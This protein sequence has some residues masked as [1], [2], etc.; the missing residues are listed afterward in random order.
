MRI[1]PA[2][3]LPFVRAATA[4]AAWLAF[5]ASAGSLWAHG[6]ADDGLIWDARAI[7]PYT[8]SLWA[9]AHVPHTEIYARVRV[10]DAPAPASTSLVVVAGGADERPATETSAERVAGRAGAEGD[11]EATLPVAEPGVLP[12][13]VKLDGSAGHAEAEASLTIQ[14][15]SERQWAR[16]PF[17]VGTAVIIALAVAL[18][19]WRRRRPS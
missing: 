3:A 8:V 6:N 19:G 1:R 14:S 18:A 9:D 17:L 13:A 2:R 5:G 11:F 16:P 15:E 10:G 7:G 12:I 4:L